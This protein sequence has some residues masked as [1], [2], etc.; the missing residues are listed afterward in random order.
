MLS[1]RYR[2]PDGFEGEINCFNADFDSIGGA[3]ITPTS[4]TPAG[5]N[6]G[7]SACSADARPSSS[8]MSGACGQNSDQDAVAS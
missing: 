1:V 8:E 5:T 6:G 7:R 3:P 2:D 4:S